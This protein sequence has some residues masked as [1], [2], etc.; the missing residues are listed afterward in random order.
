MVEKGE[1]LIV[2]ILAVLF[3]VFAGYLFD[4]PLRLCE[5]VVCIQMI[6]VTCLPFRILWL[7]AFLDL[8]F[9]FVALGTGWW[10]FRSFKVVKRE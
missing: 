8:L 9:W 5:P 2:F 3:T 7:N 6:G 10:V 4:F 1:L